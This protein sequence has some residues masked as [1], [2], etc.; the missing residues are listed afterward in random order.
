L[1]GGGVVRSYGGWS[2]VLSLRKFQEGI[3]GDRGFWE[4]GISW[5]GC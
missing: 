1:V 2:A 3:I 5:R 4:L